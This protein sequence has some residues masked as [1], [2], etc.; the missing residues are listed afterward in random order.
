MNYFEI[1]LVLIIVAMGAWVWYLMKSKNDKGGM[2]EL[3]RRQAEQKEEHKQKILELL[4]NKDR[5]AND[6]VQKLV[7]VSD[8]TATRYLNEL[9]KEGKLRQVGERGGYVYYE[10]A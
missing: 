2:P 6:D 7:G 4:A 9:E 3:A 8:A 10:N 1:V 5:I